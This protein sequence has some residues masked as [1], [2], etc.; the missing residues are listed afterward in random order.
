M[1]IST[2][3]CKIRPDYNSYYTFNN[4]KPSYI[5]SFQGGDFLSLSESEIIKRVKES[6]KTDNLI[7]HGTEAKVYK[8]EN[9]D[10]CVRLPYESSVISNFKFSKE[11]SPED[12]INHVRAKLGIHESILPFFEGEIIN[13]Y[14]PSNLKRQKLQEYVANMPVRSYT[15]LLHYIAKAANEKMLFDYRGNNL[16]IDLK[17]NQFTAIDFN[18]MRSDFPR[19]VRP[20]TEI[21]MALTGFKTQEDIK[22]KI[23]KKIMLAGLD[24]FNPKNIPCMSLSLFDFDELIKTHFNLADNSCEN[25][26]KHILNAFK[27]LKQAKRIELTRKND[28]NLLNLKLQKV[29]NILKKL[30]KS[31]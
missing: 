3:Y 8:I 17:K 15:N 21:Y 2:N 19:S 12:R 13:K 29:K 28:A 10:Y 4:S 26:Y 7:G 23:F 20:L 18:K 14:L 22:Q 1:Q 25:K 16:I 24:E 31:L 6:I 30:I 9:T 11:L 27:E 5:P